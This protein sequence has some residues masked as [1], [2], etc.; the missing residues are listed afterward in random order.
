M[1]KIQTE[2]AS[3]LFKLKRI[4]DSEKLQRRKERIRNKEVKQWED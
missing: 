3:W 2:T 1:Y 4:F